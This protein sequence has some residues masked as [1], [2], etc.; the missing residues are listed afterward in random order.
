[1]D[2]RIAQ[3]EEITAL[4]AIFGDDLELHSDGSTE[5]S[6]ISGTLSVPV[7]LPDEVAVLVKNWPP[8]APSAAAVVSGA[9]SSPKAATLRWLPPVKIRFFMKEG[10]PST[11]CLDVVIDC[12]W[13]LPGQRRRLE[14][15]VKQIWEA[16]GHEVV[17]FEL[18][19]FLAYDLLDSF[20]LMDNGQL[21]L[22]ADEREQTVPMVWDTLLAHEQKMVA[23]E[24]NATT[25]ECGV[26]FDERKGASCVKFMPCGHVFCRDCTRN[27]FE[28]LIKDNQT[29]SLRCM[30]SSCVKANGNEP[31]KEP[32]QLDDATLAGLLGDQL[33][34]RYSMLA[35]KNRLEKR[36]DIAW[37]PRP[38]CQQ[39]AIKDKDIEKMAVCQSCSFAF[40]FIC[41]RSWHGTAYCAVK[42]LQRTIEDYIRARDRGDQKKVTELEFRYGAKVLARLVLDYENEAESI[43]WKKENASACPTCGTDIERTEGCNH[44]TCSTC[45]THFC[46]L[47]GSWLNP[48]KPY[49]HY[50]DPKSPCNQ[51]LFFGSRIE[52]DLEQQDNAQAA[53]MADEDIPQEVIEWWLA[54]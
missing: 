20:K 13:L 17:L 33:F 27:Y 53:G 52:Q 8:K 22:W 18:S 5:G 31:A 51:L 30:N 9:A 14:L 16:N 2:D 10:Y 49:V 25:F 36:R 19:Q 11:E 7:T 54:D 35:E 12:R 24:F 46:Y 47:C 29:E 32:G 39:M 50:N 28:V 6:H 23:A 40:C 15:K 38:F 26:C 4:Q 44:I 42:D 43:K 1:M 41:Q 3:E 37:C 45:G 21:V 48:S 34:Q